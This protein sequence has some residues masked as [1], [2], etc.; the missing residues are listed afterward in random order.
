MS[1]KIQREMDKIEIPKELRERSK[2]G[3]MQA[4]VE[5]KNQKFNLSIKRVA[6]IA[7]L[8]AVVTLF[9]ILNQDNNNH[10]VDS[11]NEP[12][13]TIENSWFDENTEST[14]LSASRP[15]YTLDQ[16]IKEA[17]VIAQITVTE[18]VDVLEH[19]YD[20]NTTLEY[21]E[22]RARIDGYLHDELSYGNEIKF[23]QSGGSNIRFEDDPLLEVGEMY[24]LF[25]NK[26]DSVFGEVL[27]ITG[28]PQG[29]YNKEA[30]M[31]VKQLDLNGDNSQK[32]LSAL[33]LYKILTARN[34]E[35]DG[36][37]TKPKI[38][39]ASRLSY[40]FDQMAN[41]ADIIANLT[42]TDVVEVIEVK[43][44]EVMTQEF[45]SYK[46]TVNR[47][48]QN[49][50]GYEQE[51]NV[52]QEGGPNWIYSDDPLLEVDETYILFLDERESA[53]LGTSLFMTGG[54][55]GR[56]NKVDDQFVRQLNP[57]DDPGFR[58]LTEREMIEALNDKNEELN[59]DL[60]I[61]D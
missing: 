16:S 2:A 52:V 54:P 49:K 58:R 13:V 60:S 22:Y 4:H 55:S 37:I 50:L 32:E 29:R 44:N 6:V 59:I 18:I 42:V 56:Y 9:V 25:L 14:I 40:T 47:Y 45:T 11:L 8:I 28:G 26:V 19:E 23:L 27:R 7:V 41:E 46:A 1:N 15:V 5:K 61:L 10:Q 12:I 31:Y 34:Q 39:Q 20:E 17:D 21:T 35:L 36:G 30:D 51:I 53:H 57:T 48:Y 3:V 33:E 38:L 24:L 43:H